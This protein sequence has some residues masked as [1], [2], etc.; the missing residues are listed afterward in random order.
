[1]CKK[2]KKRKKEEKE[3]ERKNSKKCKTHPMNN[4]SYNQLHYI[5]KIII[6]KYIT[7]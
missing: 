4:H 2:K 5:L 7:N 3:E 1:M 6:I